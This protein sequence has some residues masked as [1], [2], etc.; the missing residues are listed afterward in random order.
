MI[1]TFLAEPVP[2]WGAM[3]YAYVSTIATMWITGCLK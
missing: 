3:I 2:L 1:E